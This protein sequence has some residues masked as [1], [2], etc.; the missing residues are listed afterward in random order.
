VKN[1]KLSI[2][3]V[4]YNDSDGLNK[5]L[6]SLEKLYNSSLDW[7]HIIIDASPELNK[8]I[9][10]KYQKQSPLRHFA[11]AAQGIYLAMNLGIEKARGD[12][13]WFLNGGDELIG[14]QSLQNILEEF[15]KMPNNNMLIARAALYEKNQFLFNSKALKNFWNGLVGMNKICHQ[16]VLYRRNIFKNIGEFSHTLKLAADYDHHWRYY[17]SGE[18]ALFSNKTFVK[19][20]TE[21][22]SSKIEEVFQEFQEIHKNYS[23]QINFFP[24]LENLFLYFYYK[25]RIRLQKMLGHSFLGTRLKKTW[26]AFK[27]LTNT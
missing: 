5:T 23:K 2:I 4:T 20:N 6:L 7:E 25:K 21:G 1:I 18:T 11:Q 8:K 26:R 10:E 24:R 16:A 17:L 14:S 12:I 19:F 13:L 15:S 27:R 9:I 22:A 3:T